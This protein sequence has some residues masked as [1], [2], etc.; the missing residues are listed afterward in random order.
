MRIGKIIYAFSFI[1]IRSSAYLLFHV[2]AKNV[3]R[4]KSKLWSLTFCISEYTEQLRAEIEIIKPRT[5][6]PRNATEQ[7]FK[8]VKR[9]PCFESVTRVIQNASRVSS[10]RLYLAKL[11]LPVYRSVKESLY[12]NSLGFIFSRLLHDLTIQH[13]HEIQNNCNHV[14]CTRT[15]LITIFAQRKNT[16]L[17]S[18]AK[19]AGISET[20]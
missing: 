14:Y 3:R 12:Q 6:C 2:I 17:P 20:I 11:S 15:K 1:L 8:V 10:V 18:D 4:T 9:S 7:A 19:F 16:T 5:Y 13:K